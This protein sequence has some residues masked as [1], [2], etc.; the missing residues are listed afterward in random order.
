[1]YTKKNKQRTDIEQIY[2]LSAFGKTLL[3]LLLSICFY[4]LYQLS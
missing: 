4:R 2:I 1:V 3:A